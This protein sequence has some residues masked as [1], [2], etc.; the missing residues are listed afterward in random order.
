MD[1]FAL[2]W[3][4]PETRLPPSP[5]LSSSVSGSLGGVSGR[6]SISNSTFCKSFFSRSV[7]GNERGCFTASSNRLFYNSS[8]IFLPSISVAKILLEKPIIG[9]SFPVAGSFYELY[10]GRNFA[11]GRLNRNQNILGCVWK[12]GVNTEFKFCGVTSNLCCTVHVWLTD[13]VFSLG[14]TWRKC[15]HDLQV[16]VTLVT[17]EILAA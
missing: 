10:C 6:S 3:L 1:V 11:F 5:S 9:R 13:W 8:H 4:P 17:L 16:E 2:A 7:R 15:V 12:R 14:L